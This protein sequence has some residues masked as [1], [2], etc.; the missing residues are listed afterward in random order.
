MSDDAVTPTDKAPGTAIKWDDSNL[1]VSYAN[2]VTT[3]ATREEVS[4][5]F[6]THKNWA[7]APSKELHV[8]LSDRIILSPFAA[9]RLL[10]VLGKTLEDYEERY[11]TIDVD[12]PRQGN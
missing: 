2:V 11:G 10:Q 5:L 7:G 3:T 8:G 4:L 12:P 6:G 1:T 9:K